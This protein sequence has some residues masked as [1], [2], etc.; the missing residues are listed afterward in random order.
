MLLQNTQASVLLACSGLST[1]LRRKKTLR[2]LWLCR[3]TK[4][5]HHVE[6]RRPAKREDKDDCEPGGAIVCTNESPQMHQHRRVIREDG[7]FAEVRGV[8]K[9]DVPLQFERVW[10]TLKQYHVELGCMSPAPSAY[11]PLQAR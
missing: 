8:E 1:L 11:L 6:P 5:N 9:S 2:G 3:G 10:R 4:E 7:P